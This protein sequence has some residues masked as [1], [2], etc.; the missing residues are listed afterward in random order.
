MYKDGQPEAQSYLCHCL[1]EKNL[2]EISRA[3]TVTTNVL[4]H[5]QK[6]N[7]YRVND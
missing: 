2:F 5:R 6:S 1:T 4:V 7:N 3:P